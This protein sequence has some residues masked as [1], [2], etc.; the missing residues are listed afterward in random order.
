MATKGS[1]FGSEII[2]AFI[3]GIVIGLITAIMAKA[4]GVPSDYIGMV[5]GGIAGGVVGGL[6][7]FLKT[8]DLMGK[9]GKKK[10]ARKK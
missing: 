10:K 9:T 2:I 3:A 4:A 6:Y 5:S 8:S 7:Q 1:G